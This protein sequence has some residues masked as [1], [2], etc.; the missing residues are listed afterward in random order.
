MIS[1]QRLNQEWRNM[2]RAIKKAKINVPKIYFV[3]KKNNKIFMEY[4]DEHVTL[5]KCLESI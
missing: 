3:D 4:L 2:E 5:K 1:N